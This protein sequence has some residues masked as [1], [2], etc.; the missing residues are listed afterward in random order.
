MPTLQSI[1]FDFF[2]KSLPEAVAALRTLSRISAQ[3]LDQT[4]VELVKVRASQINDCAYCLRL[5]LNQARKAGVPQVALDSLAIWRE[6]PGFTEREQA[7]LAWT[8]A[9]TDPGRRAE[10]GSARQALEAVFTPEQLLRL[11]VAIATINAWN[12]IAGTLRF[13]PPRAELGRER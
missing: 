11:T 2:S 13:T 1:D 12:R 6:A 4:L 8:E 5:H 7:A 10:I 9:L 3:D